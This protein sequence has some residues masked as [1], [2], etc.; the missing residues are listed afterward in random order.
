MSCSAI[1]EECVY[2]QIYISRLLL[3][4]RCEY[5]IVEYKHSFGV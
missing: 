2:I 1:K 3:S 4:A 5:K